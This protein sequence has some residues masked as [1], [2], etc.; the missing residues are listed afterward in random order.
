[1]KQIL[2]IIILFSACA[3][4]AQSITIDSTTFGKINSIKF[5]ETTDSL[6]IAKTYI[7]KE[8]S[9]A[10]SRKEA[11]GILSKYLNDILAELPD[12][13]EDG[14]PIVDEFGQSVGVDHERIEFVRDSSILAQFEANVIEWKAK[15]NSG[16]KNL[17]EGRNMK[18]EK[19]KAARAALKKVK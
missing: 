3:I 1:M 6:V 16:R 10:L 15:V 8:V 13:D 18:I 5:T 14:N 17:N 7:M 11:E 2:I 12:F 4:S 9:K 19:I